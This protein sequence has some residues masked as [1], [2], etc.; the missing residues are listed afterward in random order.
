M[1][2]KGTKPLETERLLLRP[3]KESDAGAA[4]AHWMNDPNVTKYLTWTPHEEIA[5][6]R[7]LLK[8]WE[9]ECRAINCYHWAI[10][11]KDGNVLIGD[12][13]ILQV[14][15]WNERGEIGYCLGKAWWGNGYMTE[16]LRE[17]LR[18]LFEEVGFYRL[19]GCHAAENVGSSRVMEKCGL[20]YEGIRRKFMRLP[21]TGERVDIVVRGILREDYFEKKRKT[22]I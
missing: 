9:E 15:D 7:A 12:L 5:V 6:T 11:L 21:S 8:T 19:N 18:Y 2:H 1:Q 10:V 3:W 22:G 16:A 13:N 4:F 20:I 17:V 14:D